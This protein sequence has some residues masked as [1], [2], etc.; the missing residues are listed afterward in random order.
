MPN[1]SKWL[2]RKVLSNTS[3]QPTIDS[4]VITS[5]SCGSATCQTT[6]G[7]GRHCQNSKISARLANSTYVLRS[8][9]LGTYCVHH[10]LNC[11]RA[12]TLCCTANSD[13]SSTLTINASANGTTAPVSIVLG[14]NSPVTKPMA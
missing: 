2:I 9:D 1:S 4:A 13:I 11:L 5:A 8:T 7:I 6:V 14:T 12:I 10:C 3:T